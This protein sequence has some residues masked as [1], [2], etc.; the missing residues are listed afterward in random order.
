MVDQDTGELGCIGAAGRS[1]YHLDVP[2]TGSSLP[3][4]P[5]SREAASGPP[6]STALGGSTMNSRVKSV[7]SA[8][9]AETRNGASRWPTSTRPPTATPS[10]LANADDSAMVLASA[11]G[12]PPPAGKWATGVSRRGRGRVLGDGACGRSAHA[13]VGPHPDPIA[14]RRLVAA[15]RETRGRPP[16]D[17]GT[18]SQPN[19]QAGERY[20]PAHPPPRRLRWRAQW[21]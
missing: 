12:C 19:H 16:A 4:V 5:S 20:R 11:E 18:P 6:G 3:M 10:R 13:P 8:A 17:G 9:R 14:P 2:T 7:R 15:R 21:G 1:S